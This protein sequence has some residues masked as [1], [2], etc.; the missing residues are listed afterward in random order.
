MQCM[1]IFSL[2]A[3]D[4]I[5]ALLVGMFFAGVVTT[6]IIGGLIATMVAAII[7]WLK[8]KSTKHSTAEMDYDHFLLFLVRRSSKNAAQQDQLKH[9]TMKH[10][11]PVYDTV[12]TADNNVSVVGVS[13][14][15]AYG[16]TK[17]QVIA[18]FRIEQNTLFFSCR[19]QYCERL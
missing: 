7:V 11:L 3:T 14:N 17:N 19:N 13:N 10:A 16:I 9:S 12:N 1:L 4:N 5:A 2:S 15:P 8:S 18:A 6:L